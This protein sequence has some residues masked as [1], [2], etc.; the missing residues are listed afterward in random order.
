LLHQARRQYHTNWQLIKELCLCP[1]FFIAN[2]AASTDIDH[3]QG[4][5]LS[6]RLIYAAGESYPPLI[7]PA[8]PADIN[9]I[10]GS[11]YR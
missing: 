2:N 3:F 6:N 1:V 8:K 5:S 4:R 7:A 9:P 10:V 11:C